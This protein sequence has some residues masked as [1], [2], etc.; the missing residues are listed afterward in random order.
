[1]M[2][3]SPNPPEA[4]MRAIARD[5]RPVKPSPRPL[6]LALQTAPFALLVSSLILLA[7]G[8]RYNYI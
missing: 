7:M 6:Q 4:L 5:L 3:R 8:I 1:M 2:D